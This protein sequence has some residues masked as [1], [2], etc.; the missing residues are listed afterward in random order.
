[1]T[2]AAILELLQDARANGRGWVARC[3]AH[4]DRTPSLSVAS[5][6]DGRTLLR[7]HAECSVEEI[8]SAMGLR[9]CDLFVRR[10]ILVGRRRDAAR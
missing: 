9:M 8:V 10:R 2:T 6:V 7:C 3:P 1:M 5:G 4:D